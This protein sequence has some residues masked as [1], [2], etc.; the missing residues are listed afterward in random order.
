MGERQECSL[1]PRNLMTG[2]G[3]WKWRFTNSDEG[4]TWSRGVRSP[5]PTEFQTL[6]CSQLFWLH[7]LV[8]LEKKTKINFASL[9]DN[10]YYFYIIT[11][12]CKQDPNFRKCFDLDALSRVHSGFQISGASPHPTPPRIHH[13]IN[14]EDH[15]SSTFIDTFDRL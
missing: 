11:A 3:V 4:H 12:E 5:A 15:Q 13:W 10:F 9:I 7:W 1:C 6:K 2:W 14:S 8:K